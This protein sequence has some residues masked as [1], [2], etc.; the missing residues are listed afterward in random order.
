MEY[1]HVPRYPALFVCVWMCIKKY[2]Y[3][4]KSFQLKIC[5]QYTLE[6]RLDSL[7]GHLFDR[8]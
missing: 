7:S 1:T 3:E 8:I 6:T 2:Y 4:K 5:I